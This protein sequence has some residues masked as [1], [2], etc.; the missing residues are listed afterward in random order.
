VDYAQGLEQEW[1]DH[2]LAQKLKSGAGIQTRT[3]DVYVINEANVR[4]YV[5]GWQPP[6]ESPSGPDAAGADGAAPVSPSEPVEVGPSDSDASV[7]GPSEAD[8]A[9]PSGLEPPSIPHPTLTASPSET[10]F[11]MNGEAVSVPEA[12]LVNGNNYLQVRAI[13]ALLDGTGAQFNV[14]WDG[15]YAVI[16]TGK[17]YGGTANPATLAETSDVRES[18]TTFKIDGEVVGFDNAYLIDGDT[19][20]LQLRE[21]AE[22]LSGT[23]SRFNVYWDEEAGQ[24]VLE[25]GKAYTGAAS[26]PASEEE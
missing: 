2:P 5:Y 19:N 6:T 20:Y 9:T 24:A 15:A 21:F 11:I 3:S 18:F 4:E 22:K 17:P 10:S 23:E 8:V 25:P 26:A 13:A 14:S 12:Y 7:V 16:E 1:A